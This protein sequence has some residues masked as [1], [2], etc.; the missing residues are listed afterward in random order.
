[1]PA[2]IRKNL[3][4]SPIPLLLLLNNSCEVFITNNERIIPMHFAKSG[5]LVGLFEALDYMT[6]NQSEPLWDVCAGARSIFM[7]PHITEKQGINRLM[8]AYRLPHNIQLKYLSDQWEI[9]KHIAEKE[10]AAAPW[11]CEVLF[12]TKKWFD[13]QEDL[14]WSKFYRY[15]FQSGWQRIQFSFNQIERAFIWQAIIEVVEKR[16]LKPRHYIADTV[17]HL[18]ALASNRYP[19]FIPIDN[20]QAAAPIKLLQQ[21]FTDI[22]GLKNYYPTF[23]GPRTLDQMTGQP[24]Y[25]S[26][27]FPTLVEGIPPLEK[28]SNRIM[29][30]LREVK[31]LIDTF[32]ERSSFLEQH[33]KFK[34]IKFDYFH[35]EKDIYDEIKLSEAIA[36][37]DPRFH[38][39]ELPFCMHSPFWR[40]CIR[41]I[42]N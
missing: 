5:A 41:I 12:F 31:L 27:N 21:I 23:M 42:N 28:K 6:Q 35:T 33:P 26:L 16:N 36:A 29:V 11:S 18:F 4:Y 22:Y 34:L 7:L 14:A 3:D 19:G 2:K 39:S 20:E 9:F 37:E 17:K 32:K 1:L 15:V 10:K 38:Y 8:K 30:D 24:I 40:G 25:Y 13:S